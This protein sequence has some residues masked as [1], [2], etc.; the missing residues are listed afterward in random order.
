MAED[1]YG[2]WDS[3]SSSGSSLAIAA[4]ALAQL[5]A[6]SDVLRRMG[7]FIEPENILIL[8]ELLG[9]QLPS[10]RALRADEAEDF[11][12]MLGISMS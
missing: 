6:L 12:T 8:T 2:H 7:V 11:L 9:R 5:G 4:A 3:G 1:A 10:L